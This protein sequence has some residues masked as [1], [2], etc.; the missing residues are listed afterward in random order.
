MP[1]FHE[2]KPY[3]KFIAARILPWFILLMGGIAMYIGID[4]MLNALQSKDWLSVEGKIVES[5]IRTETSSSSDSSRRSNTTY[6]ANIIYEY[7]ANG[8]SFTGKRVSYGEYGRENETHA[9]GI[10]KRYPQ[11]EMV[12]VYYDPQKPSESVL[13]PG[14]HGIPWFF[15]ALG[16][17]I[18][19][20][21]FGLVYFLPKMAAK[22][23]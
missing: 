22:P 20:F 15:F 13:E 16:I 6:H 21:G 10:S 11:G 8:E 18:M 17:P 7:L 4:S 12:V 19:I 23:R 1:A 2:L 5:G 3:Q 9:A 14:L